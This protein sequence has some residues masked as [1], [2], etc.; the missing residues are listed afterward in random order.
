[1]FS[2]ESINVSVRVVTRECRLSEPGPTNGDGFV[3]E[4]QAEERDRVH[5]VPQTTQIW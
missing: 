1:M 3:Q 2:S 4:A 5:S